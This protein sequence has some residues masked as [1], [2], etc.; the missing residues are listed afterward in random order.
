MMRIFILAVCGGLLFPAGA[1][2]QAPD[3]LAEL[4]KE[5][6]GLRVAMERAATVGAR[7]QLLVGRVQIQEQRMA[8][9]ARRSAA[10]REEMSRLDFVLSEGSL[11]VKNLEGADART[12]DLQ[13]EIESQLESLRAQLASTEKRRSELASE[14]AQLSQQMSADQGRLTDINNQL[15]QLERSLAPPKQ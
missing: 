2:A 4:L 3:L 13:K 5:M 8:E 12:P 6:R 15:D 7:I 9:L 1:H 11:N 10:L 14:D